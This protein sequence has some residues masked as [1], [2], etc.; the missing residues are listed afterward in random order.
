MQ[1]FLLG[2]TASSEESNKT[3]RKWSMISLSF[4]ADCLSITVSSGVMLFTRDENQMGK[5]NRTKGK[6]RAWGNQRD[7]KTAKSMDC[8]YLIW[9]SSVDMVHTI[10]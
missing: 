5:R 1:R 8:T 2:K 4:R 6:I 7:P 3:Q 10:H 9:L